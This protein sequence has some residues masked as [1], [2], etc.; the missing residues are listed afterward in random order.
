MGYKG[1]ILWLKDRIPSTP[2]WLY[3]QLFEPSVNEGI[4]VVSLF[5]SSMDPTPQK[6]GV[7][8]ECSRNSLSIL[9]TAS[10]TRIMLPTPQST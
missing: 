7:T 8:A 4:S 6:L 1:D 10:S 9:P 2:G 5:K 3:T